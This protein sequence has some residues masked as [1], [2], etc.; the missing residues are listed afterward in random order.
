MGATSFLGLNYWLGDKVLAVSLSIGIVVFASVYGLVYIL[1]KVKK[2]ETNKDRFRIAEIAALS[3]YAVIAIVAGIFTLHYLTVE[4]AKKTEIKTVAEN[5]IKEIEIISTVYRKQVEGWTDNFRSRLKNAVRGNNSAMLKK[6]GLSTTSDDHNIEEAVND[7]LTVKIKK[8]ETSH[9]EY[10]K[11][12]AEAN[13]FKDKG[14]AAVNAW[15]YFSI[16]NTLTNIDRIKE[17][18]IN[19]LLALST[20]IPDEVKDMTFNPPAAETMR[21]RLTELEEIDFAGGAYG[22]WAAVFLITNLATLFPYLFGNRG[23]I[24]FGDEKLRG[25]FIFT[26]KKQ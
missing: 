5:S 10:A 7:N 21:N 2:A 14:L 11:I 20:Q 19:D 18:Y 24:K 8:T 16:M 23:R 4:S 12:E 3:G 26:E 1:V 13:S 6:Y 9:K 17:S 15:S 25:G 22:L